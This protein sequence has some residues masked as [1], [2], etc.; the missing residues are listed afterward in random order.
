MSKEALK[1]LH[2]KSLDGYTLHLLEIKPLRLSGWSGFELHLQNPQGLF[3]R[4]YVIKGIYSVGGKDGVHPWMD[5]DYREDLEFAENDEIK[6]TLSLS[7]SHLDQKLI[8]ILGLA[9]P[10]GGHLMVSY[11]GDQNIHKQTIKSLSKKIPPVLTPLGHLLFMA[12]FQYIK[13]WYLSEGGFEGPRKLWGEK[14]PDEKWTQIFV[15][16]TTRQI[17]EFLEQKSPPISAELEEEADQRAK[18]IL[19][20]IG[21]HKKT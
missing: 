21:S 7:R 19:R 4:Q 11:E 16:K 15:D 17:K 10:P 6:D 14:A 3:S 1:N 20:V 12:G 5:L 9:I 8:S 2:N 18:I 13:D